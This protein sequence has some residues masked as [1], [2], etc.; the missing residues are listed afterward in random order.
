MS[1]A[2]DARERL[3]L[4]A[5]MS[6]DHAAQI[7]MGACGFDTRAEARAWLEEMGLVRGVPR[8]PGQQTVLWS[9]VHELLAG[10]D[11]PRAMAAASGLKRARS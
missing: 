1:A 2:R 11:A 6:P 4:G 8:R 7:L 5:V 9:Q 10:G 3:G